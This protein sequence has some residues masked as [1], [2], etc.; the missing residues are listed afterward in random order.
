MTTPETR[1]VI[2]TM[3][4]PSVVQLLQWSFRLSSR[5]SNTKLL[6]QLI[7]N[8][9]VATAPGTG[10]SDAPTRMF[11]DPDE[12]S[13][14]IN[15]HLQYIATRPDI[16]AFSDEFMTAVVTA[17]DES[18]L[19]KPN[20]RMMLAERLPSL[21]TIVIEEHSDQLQRF[22][23]YAVYMACTYPELLIAHLDTVNSHV[24]IMSTAKLVRQRAVPECI[25]IG[26]IAERILA[27][28]KTRTS[29]VTVTLP[30]MQAWVDA[31]GPLYGI[32]IDDSDG[33]QPRNRSADALI[34]AGGF[35]TVMC[36]HAMLA[37]RRYRMTDLSPAL[38]PTMSF[39]HSVHAPTQYNPDL[40]HWLDSALL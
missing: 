4:Y 30:V 27:L 1:A 22:T 3:A 12:R 39:S 29:A 34:E 14:F 32:L 13:L 8:P 9:T 19:L 16:D 21:R 33:G 24:L 17:S 6:V 37:S 7:E 10:S 15:T 36:T 2:D 5:A 31:I 35:D 40:V 38:Q 18:G 20:T 23:P 28:I 25:T 11:N 26:S